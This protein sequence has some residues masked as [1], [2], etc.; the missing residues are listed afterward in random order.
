MFVISLDEEHK[1]FRYH[2]LFQDLLREQAMRR[3]GNDAIAELHRRASEW[4]EREGFWKEAI[5]HALA[6]GDIEKAAELGEKNAYLAVGAS[7]AKV[8]KLKQKSNRESL[9]VKNTSLGNSQVSTYLQ[10]MLIEPLTVRE[11]E[12]LEF[13]EQGLYQKEIAHRLYISTETVKTHCK[14]IYHKLGVKNR[15]SAIKKSYALNL[16]VCNET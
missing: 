12:I 4:F 7:K 1:W 16:L 2:H 10:Q 11:F 3:Y 13:L 6:T 14:H 9:G 8:I 5:K 15:R